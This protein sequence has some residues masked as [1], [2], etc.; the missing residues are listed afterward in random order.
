MA[1]DTTLNNL[2]HDFRE[3]LQELYGDRLVHLILFGSHARQES[4]PESDIDIMVVLKGLISP[5]D[6][7]FRMS[8]IKTTVNLQYDELISVIPISAFDYHN[9]QT[10][11]LEAVHQ[12]GIAV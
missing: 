10:P 2:L 4:T 8:E 9:R 6:E 5:G 7:I 3:G 1:T 12:E 11:L